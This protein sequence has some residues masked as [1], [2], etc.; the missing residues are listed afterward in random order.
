MLSTQCSRS[1]ASSRRL[2]AMRARPLPMPLDELAHDVLLDLLLRRLH[3]VD[4][5]PRLA[6]ERGVERRVGGEWW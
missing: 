6:E 3:E 4:A 1:Q 5:D 2:T